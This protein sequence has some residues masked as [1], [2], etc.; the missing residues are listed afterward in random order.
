MTKFHFI[1][2]VLCCFAGFHSLLAEDAVSAVDPQCCD[3]NTASA[4][5]FFET[6]FYPSWSQMSAAKGKEDVLA[7]IEIS[8]KRIADIC[9]LKPEEMTYENIFGAI[10]NMQDELEQTQNYMHHLSSV[11]DNSELRAV[12]EE[13]IPA[14]SAFSA[15]I[16]GNDQLWQAVKTAAAQEW[17]KSLSP[18]KQR[19]I[20]QVVDSFRESGADLPPADK[21]RKTAIELELSRLLLKFG[22][23]VLDSTKAW[24]LVITDRKQLEGMTE[25]WMHKAAAD[26]LA[27]GYGTAE[28][29]QWLIT[30]DYTSVGDVLRDCTVEAT[31]KACWEGQCSIGKVA[32]Y[33]NEPIV[34]RVME[35]RRELAELLGFRDYA[36]LK[37]AHRMVDKGAKALAFVDDM[38]DKVRP[39][40]ASE[41]RELLDFVSKVEGREVDKLKP[42]DRRFYMNRLSL[43][44]YDFDPESLR[45]YLESGNVL[46][47]MFSIFS[48]LYDISI[49]S[50]PSVCLQPGESCPEGKVEVWHKDVQ[51]FKVI[52]HKTGKHLGSFY[53]DPYPRPGK[54]AGA[55]VM[56]LRPGKRDVKGMEPHLAALV[57]NFTAPVKNGPTLYSAYDVETIFHEFGHMMHCLLSNTELRAHACTS[58]AWD[59]VELPSQLNENWTWEPEGIA[60]YAFHYQTGEPVP[61]D[62]LK[63]YIS[64]RFFMPA[65]DNMSQLSI[66]KLDLEMHMHY[67]E[68]FADKS[69]DEATN[70]LLAS[71]RIPTTQDGPSIMRHLTHCITGG[72]A[73]GYFCYKWAEVL[74]ADAFSRFANEGIMNA[75]TGASYRENI[76]SKGDSK[77]AADV[78]RD[79]M[80]RDPNPDALLRKQGLK[81]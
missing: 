74:A 43:G 61:A 70:A 14:L 16:S 63:R 45:P 24:K 23:N 56:P 5:P 73:A 77:P 40:F 36:D 3:Q 48:H 30:L 50:V 66:A 29:P 33:D 51:V 25:K 55:W 11:M 2:G 31:R 81:E 68:G 20:R 54:R 19:Y 49:I 22:K 71:M 64:S 38:I 60:T 12:Q 32:P 65:I 80:G 75:A 8:R 69:L 52:D 57:G 44:K 13:L 37:C 6:P 76:L 27:Q 18:A 39:A 15:E 59:F 67:A 62:L 9:R 42:W 47:G 53:Y 26:A 35:L 21:E 79:F 1:V 4:H 10:E 78:Y 72:Y 41:C 7:G 46:K 58:V 28:E 34:A 17:V